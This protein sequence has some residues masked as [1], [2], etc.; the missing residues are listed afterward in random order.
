MGSDFG[1]QKKSGEVLPF[2]FVQ[3][4]YYGL[5]NFYFFFNRLLTSAER[6]ISFE[7]ARAVKSKING[8]R[9]H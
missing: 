8:V 5:N 1:N 2:A 3:P 9:L 6:S 7:S 4:D